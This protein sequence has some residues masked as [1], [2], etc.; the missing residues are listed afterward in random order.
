MGG[1]DV[2]ALRGA[3]EQESL[4][5]H[6]FEDAALDV[7]KNKTEVVGAESAGDGG[8][9]VVVGLLRQGLVEMFAVAKERADDVQEEGDAGHLLLLVGA[10][11]GWLR[12]VHGA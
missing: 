11:G 12:G 5:H 9:A 4:Q 7:P 6:G 1:L 10:L 2:T 3:G 8:E